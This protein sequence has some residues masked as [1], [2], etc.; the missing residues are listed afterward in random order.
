MRLIPALDLRA[1]H[2]VR[3][4]RGDFE[5]ETRYQAAPLALLAK[6]RDLGADWLHVV[7]LDGARDGSAGNRAI[8]EKLAAR[9]AAKLQT[10]GGLRDAA[11]VAGVLSAGA[12]RAVIGSAAVTHA[13]AVRD[14]LR[15]FGPERLTL[16]FDVRLD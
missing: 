15:H 11:S 8:I 2:C 12:S 10:G 13:A 1:G 3:L 5:T 6:Y 7:D 16:A 14:W 9:G 4:L